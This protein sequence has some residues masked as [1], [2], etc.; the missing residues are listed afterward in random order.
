MRP[1]QLYTV[2][3]KLI[4][5]VIGEDRQSFP[6]PPKLITKDELKF[7]YRSLYNSSKGMWHNSEI[8][9]KLEG[10][11][12]ARAVCFSHNRELEDEDII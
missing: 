9:A 8:Q 2:E 6:R 3:K 5:T 12:H 11:L 1:S 7:R 10:I 4:K